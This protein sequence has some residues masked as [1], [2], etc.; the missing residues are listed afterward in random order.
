MEPINFDEM[1]H[2]LLK[3]DNMTDEECSSLPIYTNGEVC[4]SKWKMTFKERLHCLFRGFVWVSVLS[5]V[6]QPPISIAP[7]KTVFEKK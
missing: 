3:P 6:S 2:K 1:N 7:Q 4:V 5:G